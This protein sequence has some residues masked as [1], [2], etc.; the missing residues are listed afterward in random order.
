MYLETASDVFGS[1]NEGRE[2]VGQLDES[3]SR[4]PFTEFEKGASAIA[5]A[6]KGPTVVQYNTRTYP[7]MLLT[8]TSRKSAR[9]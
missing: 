8:W 2:R 1:L 9:K 7:A 5:I 3:V 4:S 6:A